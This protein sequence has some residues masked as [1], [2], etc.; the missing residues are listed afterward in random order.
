[1]F[2]MI[3]STPVGEDCTCSYDVFLYKEYN[4]G[5]LIL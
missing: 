1:M 2:R 4:N 5:G 3:A